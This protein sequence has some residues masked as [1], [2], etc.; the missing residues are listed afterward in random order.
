MSKRYWNKVWKI[1]NSK[2]IRR[3]VWGS[4]MELAFI[5][6]NSGNKLT[7]QK[8]PRSKTW[9]G[10]L[11]GL[12]LVLHHH[13]VLI[14]VI[15]FLSSRIILIMLCTTVLILILIWNISILRSVRLSITTWLSSLRLSLIDFRSSDTSID[16]GLSILRMRFLKFLWLIILWILLLEICICVWMQWFFSL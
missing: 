12:M 9:L 2:C 3:W 5:M 1:F 16:W 7:R 4:S 13:L 14:V 6:F 10:D 11:V 8:L 15:I